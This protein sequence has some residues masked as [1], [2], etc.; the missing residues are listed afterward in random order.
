MLNFF[1][2]NK[3]KLVDLQNFGFCIDIYF[4]KILVKSKGVSVGREWIEQE[5]FLFLEVLEM[6]KD[7]WN[8]VLEYVGSC[9]QD[10]CI[11]YFLRF[12]IEDLYFENLDVFFGFL[13]YQFVFFSQLG[14]LVMSIVV[15]L[16]F[17]VDFCVV[18]VVVKV[19]LEEFFWVWEEVLL[20]LVEVYVKKV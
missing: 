12:F 7:D 20:E 14:N 5:I 4:K 10:E 8:K 15:F 11:F 16:V 9:I 17:V 6:Y 3:E 1:E 2:K 19:V 18:F 13:V